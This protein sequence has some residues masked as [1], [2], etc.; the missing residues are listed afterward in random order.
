MLCAAGS[1]IVQAQ[2]DFR[3]G[4]QASPS[5]S[6]MSTNDANINGN[7]T[8]LGLKLGLLGEKYIRENYA[9][10]FG[11]G[12]G[13][14]EGGTLRYNGEGVLWPEVDL[15]ADFENLDPGTNL[16]YALQYLEIPVGFKMRTQQFGYFRFFADIPVITLGILTQAKG[17]ISGPYEN[18]PEGVDIRKAANFLTFSWGV[19]GGTEYEI[20]ENIALIG[21]INF[22]TSFVDIT[23]DKGTTFCPEGSFDCATNPQEEDSKGKVSIITIKLGVMF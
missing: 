22:Q 13:F 14:N 17:T 9:L 5:F 8:N 4:F 10:T 23:K 7:G 15:P 6:W 11:L 18:A 19:G 12:F 2:N 20:G 16:K 3:F 21:G 1:V